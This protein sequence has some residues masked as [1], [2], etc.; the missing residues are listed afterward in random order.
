MKTIEKSS[1]TVKIDP[2]KMDPSD[3]Q[4]AANMLHA[5]STLLRQSFGI[6][7]MFNDIQDNPMSESE[8]KSFAQNFDVV[9]KTCNVF[10]AA[11]FAFAKKQSEK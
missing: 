11:L 2:R 6:V 9:H 1:G 7:C 10:S 8:L 4:E 3:I 5:C